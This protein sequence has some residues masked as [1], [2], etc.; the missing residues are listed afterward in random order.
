[1]SA[2]K[3]PSFTITGP[4]ANDVAADSYNVALSRAQTIATRPGVEPGAWYIRDPRGLKVAIVERHSD[5]SVTTTP[6]QKGTDH[7]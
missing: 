5:R 6:T 3:T 7:A 2:R 1:M 4:G